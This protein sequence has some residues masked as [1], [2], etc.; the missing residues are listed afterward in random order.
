[1]WCHLRYR[2]LIVPI[3]HIPSEIISL[4]EMMAHSLVS[5]LLNIKRML[6]KVLA[7]YLFHLI[8]ILVCEVVKVNYA[9]EHALAPVVLSNELYQFLN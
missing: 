2:H 5:Q 3:D 8:A 7:E 9:F 4:C 6:L 1:M